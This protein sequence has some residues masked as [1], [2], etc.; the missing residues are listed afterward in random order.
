MGLGSHQAMAYMRSEMTKAGLCL[1]IFAP[2]L[3]MLLPVKTKE[4]N[5]EVHEPAAPWPHLTLHSPSCSVRGS[6]WSAHWRRP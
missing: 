4:V 3:Y 2:I 6:P 1:A 5:V